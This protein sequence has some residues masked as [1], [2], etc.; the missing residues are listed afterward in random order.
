M[1]APKR[2]LALA[3]ALVAIA[4]CDEMDFEEFGEI[5]KLRTLAVRVDPPEIGPGEAAVI[6]ALV[7]GAD[8]PMRMTWELCLFTDGPDEFYR[9]SEQDGE[10]LGAVIG[11]TPEVVIPYD[12]V[13]ESI[14]D[15]E[16]ICSELED[17]E[18]GDFVSL[19]DCDRGFPFTVRLTVE[20]AD[21]EGDD[22]E[23]AT[24]GLLLLTE[25]EAALD[26]ANVPPEIEGLVVSGVATR[27]QLVELPLTEEPLALQALV[28]PDTAAEEYARIEE[29]GTES[30]ERERLQ[31]SWFATHGMMER[32]RTFFA[33]GTVSTAELQ[34]NELNL[35]K[36]TTPATVGD[37]GTIYIVLRDNRGG[38]DFLSR[39]FVVVESDN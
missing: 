31:L 16:S 8:G 13:V 38:V 25:D 32:T 11:Q 20:L 3:L 24:A 14:G 22:R 35:T 5:S 4:G 12:L 6:D 19:P 17:V 34:S 26:R 2:Q 30:E 7:A 21:G 10:V 1:M 23:I 36:G 15:V 39:S 18:L 28:E 27:G 29:D 33:E 37:E 9:C